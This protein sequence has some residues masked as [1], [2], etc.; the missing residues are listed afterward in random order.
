MIA[1]MI[2][3][4]ANDSTWVGRK[5]VYISPG[6]IS[7]GSIAHVRTLE[8]IDLTGTSRVTLPR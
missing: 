5:Q 1:K 7:P 2:A 8:R 3:T 4:V 6:S